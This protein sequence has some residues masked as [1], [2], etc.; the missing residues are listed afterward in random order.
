MQSHCH[1]R[2]FGEEF[3]AELCRRRLFAAQQG[4]RTL[5]VSVLNVCLLQLYSQL[6]A[7]MLLQLRRRHCLLLPW[8]RWLYSKGSGEVDAVVN[9]QIAFTQ[10]RLQ[11]WCHL[12]LLQQLCGDLTLDALADD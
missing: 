6:P 4:N 8:F 9:P 7:P 10:L 3:P 1:Q 5:S 12:L 2:L 11:K